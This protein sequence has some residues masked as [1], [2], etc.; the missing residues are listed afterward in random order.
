VVERTK[1][2][3]R[4]KESRK[5]KKMKWEWKEGIMMNW[6]LW[7][8]HETERENSGLK[9]HVSMVVRSSETL[10]NIY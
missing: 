6:V 2:L 3:T 10:G 1:T 9:G 5:D 4:Q 7:E 8:G